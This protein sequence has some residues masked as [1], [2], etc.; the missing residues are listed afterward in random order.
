MIKFIGLLDRWSLFNIDMDIAAKRRQ[1][2]DVKNPPPVRHTISNKLWR[3]YK[4][5]PEEHMA[6][7]I[8]PPSHKASTNLDD[9]LIQAIEGP[10]IVRY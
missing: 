4:D 5:V 2:A 3:L 7:P 1:Q 9:K 10:K 8:P 6:E